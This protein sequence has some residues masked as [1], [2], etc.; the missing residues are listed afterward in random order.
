[1]SNK[2]SRKK[3]NKKEIA[4]EWSRATADKLFLNDMSPDTGHLSNLSTNKKGK[5]VPVGKQ[6]SGYLKSMGLLE[7]SVEEIE[8]TIENISETLCKIDVL[9]ESSIIK[10]RYKGKIYSTTQKMIDAVR[11]FDEGKIEKIDLLESAAWASDPESAIRVAQM[12]AGTGDF[13]R[14]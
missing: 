13:R 6:I 3:L 7:K 14:V 1:M 11:F 12:I 9:I 5:E 10:K 4:A 2:N 8:D